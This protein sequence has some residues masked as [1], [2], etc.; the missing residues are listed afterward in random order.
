MAAL[1]SDLD[2]KQRNAVIQ[3][4]LDFISFLKKKLSGID[5]MTFELSR[6]EDRF[7]ELLSDAKQIEYVAK[8]SNISF[9]IA[10]EKSRTANH[11][12]L[13]EAKLRDY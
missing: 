7:N 5:A 6:L 8:D 13:F 11:S 4:V 9:S 2:I 12:L 3:F 10:G 1:T